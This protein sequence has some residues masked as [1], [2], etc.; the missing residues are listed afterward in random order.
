MLPIAVGGGPSVASFYYVDEVAKRDHPSLPSWYDQLG[1]FSRQH[2]LNHLDGIL[3]PYIREQLVRVERLSRIL[4]THE[5]DAVALLHI[6]TEGADLCVLETLDFSKLRPR[7]I[8]IEHKHLTSGYKYR[9][10]KILDH[11]GYRIHDCGSDFFAC[12]R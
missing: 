7:A 3:E 12:S 5:I 9:L 4:R 2:I 8:L 6:D 11:N 1:S 10:R